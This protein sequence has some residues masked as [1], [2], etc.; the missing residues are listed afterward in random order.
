[1]QGLQGESMPLAPAG[2]AGPG[3]LAGTSQGRRRDCHP[4]RL[5]GAASELSKGWQ[6][7]APLSS[8]LHGNTIAFAEMSCQRNPEPG[9]KT[10]ASGD[11][12]ADFWGW[13]SSSAPEEGSLVYAEFRGGQEDRVRTGP[14]EWGAHAQDGGPLLTCLGGSRREL[15]P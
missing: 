3:G 8:D 12:N 10:F 7:E 13:R 2:G 11:L 5:L 9:T 15:V 4:S 6:R 14:L 1:M